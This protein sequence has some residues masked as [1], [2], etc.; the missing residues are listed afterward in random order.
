MRTGSIGVATGMLALA[1]VLSSL[2]GCDIG[3][4]TRVESLYAQGAP[5]SIAADQTTV[6]W[7][8]MTTVEDAPYWTIKSVPKK[9]LPPAPPSELVQGPGRFFTVEPD[10]PEAGTLWF[11]D[12]AGQVS[13]RDRDGNVVTVFP[14]IDLPLT[15]AT[16][17]GLA[18]DGSNIYE[19]ITLGTPQTEWQLWAIPR[20]DSPPT[21]MASEMTDSLSPLDIV[22]DG[23]SVYFSLG[24]PVDQALV[25]EIR[26]V[27]VGTTDMETLAAGVHRPQVLREFGDNLFWYE[28]EEIRDTGLVK[29]RLQRSAKDGTGSLVLASITGT[30]S[31]S[32]DENFV[33]WVDT[34]DGKIWVERV[35]H[36]GSNS[37]TSMI[38]LEPAGASNAIASDETY[39]YWSDQGAPQ[40]GLNRMLKK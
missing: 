25:G 8:E 16:S 10:G 24:G 39:V 26:R 13:R 15:D 37:I 2:A 35:P 7:N 29:G 32:V 19:L 5:V 21:K 3:Q 20:D 23:G 12:P 28:V 6:Y 36:G 40:P 4:R 30:T 38:F 34:G 14:P 17:A 22:S 11:A 9:A 27:P 1:P 31:L 18:R 33:Y